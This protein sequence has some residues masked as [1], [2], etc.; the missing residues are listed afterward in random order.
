[1][2]FELIE[3]CLDLDRVEEALGYFC[4]IDSEDPWIA[5]PEVVWMAF[6]ETRV[7]AS[8]DIKRSKAAFA[9]SLEVLNEMTD[10]PANGIWCDRMARVLVAH[11]EY[12]RALYFAKAGIK[13]DAKN[14]FDEHPRVSD[15]RMTLASIHLMNGQ[16]SAALEQYQMALDCRKRF[17]SPGNRMIVETQKAIDSLR[18]FQ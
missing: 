15:R 17:F 1:M 14:F 9:R 11:A 6:V 10:P 8:T 16:Q 5:P 18:E 13:Y 12:S 2:Y 7:F 3:C 4:E